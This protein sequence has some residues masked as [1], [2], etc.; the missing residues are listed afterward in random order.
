M[1][2]AR[3]LKLTVV[4]GGCAGLQLLYHLAKQPSW[5]DVT[6]NM[7]YDDDSM[8]RSWCYWSDRPMPLQHLVKK[9]WDKVCFKT[10]NF[11]KTES[12]LPYQYH[13]IPGDSFFD[14]F[15]EEFIPQQSNLTVEKAHVDRLERLDQ[16]FRVHV[17]D[18]DSRLSDVVFSNQPP[19]ELTTAPPQ[20]WQHFRGWFIRTD[21]PVFDPST[22]TLMDFT[23]DQADAVRFI[24]I[25]PFSANEALVEMT[26]ISA[27]VYESQ[28]YDAL[29]KS[30]LE[31]HYPGVQY[32]IERTEVG[33]IPMTD[34][35]FSRKGHEGEVLIGT[36]AGMVKATTGYAF[37]RISRDSHALA[38]HFNAPGTIPWAGTKGRFRFYDRLLLAIL[39]EQPHMGKVIFG[40]LFKYT[41]YKAILKF[42]DEQTNLWEEIKIFATLPILTF[43][44]QVLKLWLKQ[45]L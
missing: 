20:L 44:K 18:Q 36:A 11:S 13:Y 31:E 28:T 23:V 30:Y 40:R 34:A 21:T 19:A 35:C 3:R 10:T 33:K 4:G 8:Q 43:V 6:V 25:L 41:P 7:Y 5:S 22:I 42:M 38:D 32:K 27:A 15:R 2:D 37:S 26:V 16:S 39:K 29:L 17:K 45:R 9:S 12:I 1:G 24:Y 14:Y